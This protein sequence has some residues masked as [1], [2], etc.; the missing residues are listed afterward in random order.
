MATGVEA[1]A[2]VV[3]MSPPAGST[4]PNT[5]NSPDGAALL[6]K[7]PPPAATSAP[8]VGEAA[9]S[10]EDRR[11]VQEA[12]RTLGHL[13]GVADGDFGPQTRAAIVQFQSFVDEP[14]SG[15]L[16]DE[17]RKQLIDMAGRL[18]LLVETPATS[19][20]GVAASSVRSGPERL[21]RAA[22]AAANDRVEAAY[23]YRAA[24]ADGEAKAFTNLGTLLIRGVGADKPDPA[25]AKLLWLTAAAR[26]EPIA[27]FNL[28]AMYERGIG[29]DSDPAM[30]R[31]WYER[32]A[33]RG[34][35]GAR[36]A[37]K[38]LKT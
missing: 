34:H 8:P 5:P 25:D 36:D 20:R 29:V 21:N 18:S 13:S 16:S 12:L 31:K 23:W 11:G 6:P 14:E 7:G 9:W 30:A 38:R 26:G 4:Y 2:P 33:A 19:P 22:N 17:E 10:L 27:M 28:G 32:A 24:A 1:S 37:L 3:A 15:Q 35:T